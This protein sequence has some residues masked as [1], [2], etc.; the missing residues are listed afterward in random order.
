M[1][2]LRGLWVRCGIND[3]SDRGFLSIE[4]FHEPFAPLFKTHSWE[5][6]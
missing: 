2:L 5:A 3:V 1:E 6:L 4:H